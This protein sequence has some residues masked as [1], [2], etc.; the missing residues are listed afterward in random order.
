MRI[1]S[2]DQ[3]I[4][5]GEEGPLALTIGVFDGVHRGHRALIARIRGRRGLPAV[6]TFLHN[7]KRLL[8]P[9]SYEGDI[10]SL[11]QKLAALEE[12]GVALTVLIDFSLDFGKMKGRDFIDLVKNRA[13]LEFLAV[14]ANFRCGR[15]L[16]AGAAELRDWLGGEGIPVEVLPPVSEGGE[17]VSSSR[18]R[19][20]IR[21]GDFARASVLLGRP[22][23]LDLADLPRE[24]AGGGGRVYDPA[25]RF[26]VCPPPGRYGVRIYGAGKAAFP[27]ARPA[28]VIVE[29]GKIL[30][31]AP[32]EAERVEFI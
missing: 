21:A 19:A 3:F 4:T 13:A 20:A 6:L 17:A 14:G 24:A 2:W 23:A 7:P 32:F 1:K 5:R 27:A 31:P 9:G 29:D 28:E 8:S 16:D 22:V 26:R 30:V 12:E 18:V 15:G 25:A 10:L 11:R